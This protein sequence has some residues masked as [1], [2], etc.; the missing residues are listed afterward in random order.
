MRKMDALAGGQPAYKPAPGLAL[1][2]RAKA[3]GLSK[4]GR[5]AQTRGPWKPLRSYL[6]PYDGLAAALLLTLWH[7]ALSLLRMVSPATSSNRLLFIFS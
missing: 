6:Y 1:P 7:P 5:I 4:G 3:S 2:F